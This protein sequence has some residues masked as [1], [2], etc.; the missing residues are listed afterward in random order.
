M[1]IR[2]AFCVYGLLLLVMVNT[3]SGSQSLTISSL[4]SVPALNKYIYYNMED[5]ITQSYSM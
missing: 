4:Q 1:I 3:N 2:Y 5:T